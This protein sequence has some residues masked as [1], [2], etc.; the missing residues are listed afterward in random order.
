MPC[1]CF[2]GQPP[3]TTVAIAVTTDQTPARS[4]SQQAQP[5][6]HPISP[7]EWIPEGCQHTGIPSAQRHHHRLTS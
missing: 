1:R 4:P 2:I 3:E 7:E 5:P 6:E